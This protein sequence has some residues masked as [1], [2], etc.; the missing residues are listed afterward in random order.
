MFSAPA[1]RTAPGSLQGLLHVYY[2]P[3]FSVMQGPGCGSSGCLAALEVVR[4]SRTTQRALNSRRPSQAKQQRPAKFTT[5]TGTSIK[6]DTIGARQILVSRRSLTRSTFFSAL[7]RAPT[8]AIMLSPPHPQKWRPSFL[9]AH[10]SSSQ[11]SSPS[12]STSHQ[13]R[14]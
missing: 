10:L 5:C 1:L 13:T 9:T 6:R 7:L 4:F 2:W 8:T 11:S 14:N 12:P 3:D